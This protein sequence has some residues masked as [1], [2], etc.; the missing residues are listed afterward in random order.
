LII[1]LTPFVSSPVR[2]SPL[3]GRLLL[4]LLLLRRLLLLLQQQL[5]QCCVRELW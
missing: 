2:A 5:L 3:L 1:L 4:L